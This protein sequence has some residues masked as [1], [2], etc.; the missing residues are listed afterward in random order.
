M[1]ASLDDTGHP[2]LVSKRI[3]LELVEGTE[4]PHVIKN[5]EEKS[6]VSAKSTLFKLLQIVFNR[7]VLVCL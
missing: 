6:Y 7:F 5:E 2:F 4:R 1:M 3:S